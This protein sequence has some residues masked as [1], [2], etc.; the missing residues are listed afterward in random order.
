M[1]SRD[2]FDMEISFPSFDEIRDDAIRHFRGKRKESLNCFRRPGE[3]AGQGRELFKC[4]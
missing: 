2:A 4:S 1:P 3:S